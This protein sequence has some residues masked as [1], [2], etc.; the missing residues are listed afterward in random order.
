M[1]F[2]MNTERPI[3][4]I[5]YIPTICPY[6]ATWKNFHTVAFINDRGVESWVKINKETL[7]YQN[8]TLSYAPVTLSRIYK[9]CIRWRNHQSDRFMALSHIAGLGQLTSPNIKILCP[10]AKSPVRQIWRRT[11]HLQRKWAGC[12]EQGTNINRANQPYVTE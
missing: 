11:A 3:I 2:M 8:V 7:L 12:H 1:F 10:V 9:Y 4:P 5:Q 6:T